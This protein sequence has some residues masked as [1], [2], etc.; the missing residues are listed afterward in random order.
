MNKIELTEQL[1]RNTKVIKYKPFEK[2]SKD[3][4]VEFYCVTNKHKLEALSEDKIKSHDFKWEI[5]TGALRLQKKS[6]LKKIVTKLEV[7]KYAPELN[8]LHFESGKTFKLKFGIDNMEDAL[9]YASI[10]LD[11]KQIE[12]Y[13]NDFL[14]HFRN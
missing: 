10:H 4:L 13:K 8:C 3:K 9:T 1:I 6:E 11:Q 12:L 5:E 7:H 2:E 14:K